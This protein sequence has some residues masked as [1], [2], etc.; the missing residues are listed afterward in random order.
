LKPDCLE[1]KAASDELLSPNTLFILYS[2]M[3]RA[4][5]S[6]RVFLLVSRFYHE[7]KSGLK[8]RGRLQVILVIICAS[9]RGDP[10]S[11]SC[12]VKVSMAVTWDIT[13]WPFWYWY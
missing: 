9:V 4:V 8:R 2:L 6:C 5:R 13:S 1:K 10:R 3:R 11:S 7:D 12:L